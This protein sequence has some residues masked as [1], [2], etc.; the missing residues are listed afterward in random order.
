MNR[1]FVERVA[2][3]LALI[4]GLAGSALSSDAASDFGAAYDQIIDRF[5]VTALILKPTQ[6]EAMRAIF[7]DMH[8]TPYADSADGQYVLDATGRADV[9]SVL[10]KYGAVQ[11]QL[12]ERGPL[13]NDGHAS[14]FY[15]GPTA[16]FS[17]SLKVRFIPSV[18]QFP[19]VL[20]VDYSL[21]A[22]PELPAYVGTASNDINRLRYVTGG[23]VLLPDKGAL[24]SVRETADGYLIWII[25]VN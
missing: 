15:G 1:S 11:R 18:R 19:P 20:I 25:S 23:S 22:S 16:Q 6:H 12:H 7:R 10:Q 17:A 13:G 4:T 5:E 24:M 2:L 8:L 9:M 21:K 14:V 3:T